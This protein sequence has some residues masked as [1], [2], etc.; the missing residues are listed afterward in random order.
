IRLR[1]EFLSIASHELKTPLTA[2]Q[3]Q[4]QTLHDQTAP[5]DANVTQKIDHAMHIAERL[6]Q[7]IE[8]LLDVSRIATGRL[9]LNLEPFDL[10]DSVREVVERLR[11]DAS[12]A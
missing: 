7:L 2:L 4:L 9:N 6:A 10:A 3:L 12:S 8:T 11:D 1:D 5:L